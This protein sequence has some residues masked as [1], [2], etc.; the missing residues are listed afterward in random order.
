[1]IP[2]YK[3]SRSSAGGAD[4]VVSDLGA[5]ARD[6]HRA[7]RLYEKAAES[8]LWSV[9]KHAEQMIKKHANGVDGV[10]YDTLEI[11]SVGTVG[12]LRAMAIIHPDVSRG[13]NEDDAGVTLLYVTPK[14]MNISRLDAL[15][16]GSPWPVSAI[17]SPIDPGDARVISRR[18]SREEYEEAV[19]RVLNAPGAKG[20]MV[21]D[22][23]ISKTKP[24]S[25]QR[26]QILD[27]AMPDGW[28]VNEDIAWR[29]LRQEF[30]IGDER[31]IPHW[32][33]VVGG[34][35]SGLAEECEAFIMFMLGDDS[36]LTRTKL[37]GSGLSATDMA[38]IQWFQENLG[39]I[40]VASRAGEVPT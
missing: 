32:R 7:V 6:I 29:V 20:L 19:D 33:K 15:A 39:S 37:D 25:E 2:S 28:L 18:V 16:E 4:V 31:S 24:L 22:G 11:H 26:K 14:K 12:Q 1:M 40:G 36:A 35:S 10:N 23:V 27:R 13:L 17:R 8:F 34:V 5:F 21:A 30:G 38:R 9:V 3:L